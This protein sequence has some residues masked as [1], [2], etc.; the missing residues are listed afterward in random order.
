MRATQLGDMVSMGGGRA[1]RG[2]R[3]KKQ[4]HQ[5]KRGRQIRTGFLDHSFP[6]GMAESENAQGPG[7]A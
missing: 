5:K 7:L 1:G 2:S 6:N 3:K 4:G